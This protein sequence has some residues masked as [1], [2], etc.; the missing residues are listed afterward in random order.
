MFLKNTS[1]KPIKLNSHNGFI[2]AIPVGVSAIEDSAGEALLKVYK[3]ESPGGKDKYGFD[4]GHG[5]PAVMQSTEKE[6]V[7][8]GKKLAEVERFK[9]QHHLIPRAKLIETAMD[10]GV[11]DKKV[12]R[13]QIDPTIDTETIAQDINDLPIPEEIKYPVSIEEEVKN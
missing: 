1:Q 11:D 9:I 2:F 10:R 13:Y 3:I 6:W 12:R 7:K 8:N 4:N 5:I